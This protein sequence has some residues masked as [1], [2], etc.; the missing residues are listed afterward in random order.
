VDASEEQ[1]AQQA[2][3]SSQSILLGTPLLSSFSLERVGFAF[4]RSPTTF[5]RIEW[6]QQSSRLLPLTSTRAHKFETPPWAAE[7]G[8]PGANIHDNQIAELTKRTE[9]LGVQIAAL[10]TDRE[11]LLRYVQLLF[12]YGKAVLEAAV[13]SA[14]R[15][16]GFAV[17]E[18]EEYEGEWDV[19][20]QD[21]ES[22]RTALGGVEGS[23]GVIDVDKYRQL[24]A[25]I[26][27]CR[28][29]AFKRRIRWRA[30][31]IRDS[32]SHSV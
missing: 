8:V 32:R 12:G 17:P 22:G 13:R 9:E 15:L 4:C 27:R 30:D 28:E 7:I 3:Q 16:L 26:E 18:P 20:L 21:N 10:K 1:I 2:A 19:A 29:C 31:K 23:E 25:Y 11:K 24:L 5:L 6:A 14:F